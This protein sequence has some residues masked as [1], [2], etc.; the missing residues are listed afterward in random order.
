MAK[1]LPSISLRDRNPGKFAL[2]KRRCHQK[3]IPRSLVPPPEVSDESQSVIARRGM[4]HVAM[5]AD[6]V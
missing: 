2:L 1:L 5:G 4:D 3:V 6:E